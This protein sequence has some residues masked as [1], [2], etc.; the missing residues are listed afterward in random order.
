MRALKRKLELSEEK[1]NETTRRAEVVEE[2]LKNADAIRETSAQEFSELMKK[3]GEHLK[4]GISLKKSVSSLKD[5]LKDSDNNA[6]MTRLKIKDL[7]ES[8]G[9]KSSQIISYE[10]KVKDLNA[11]VIKS[12]DSREETEFM[13]NKLRKIEKELEKSLQENS[14]AKKAALAVE[15]NL[16]ESVLKCQ[17]FEDS[18][19]TLKEDLE[20]VKQEAFILR[21][22]LQS[23]RAALIAKDEAVDAAEHKVST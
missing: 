5:E 1:V 14:E 22:T 21:D 2:R 10:E 4:E 19:G 3:N 15:S 20:A 6:T 13:S 17:R 7:E 11:Q 18:V 23:V 12:K 9:S 16:A 8:L